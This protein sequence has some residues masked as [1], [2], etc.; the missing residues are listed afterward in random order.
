MMRLNVLDE[1]VSVGRAFLSAVVVPRKGIGVCIE[2]KPE[3][4][5]PWQGVSWIGV[6]IANLHYRSRGWILGRRCCG[7]HGRQ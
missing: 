1:R 3:I 2:T 6:I 4:R 7:V 5:W